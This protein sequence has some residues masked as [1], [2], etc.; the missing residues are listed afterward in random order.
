MKLSKFLPYIMSAVVPFVLFLINSFSTFI[1]FPF[2]VILYLQTFFGV[3]ALVN[4]ICLQKVETSFGHSLRLF[5]AVVDSW[6]S[7]REKIIELP[8]K[9][10]ITARDLVDTLVVPG[11][12]MN[13]ML[14]DTLFQVLGGSPPSHERI[15]ELLEKARQDRITQPEA[16]E[17]K[18]LLEEEK[19]EREAS[20]DI[21][22]SILLGLLIIF[23]L[24]VIASLFNGDG[25][26]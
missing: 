11:K 5:K 25:E 4:T 10:A 1:V 24:G 9:Q 6:K 16:E 21:I 15:K 8:R 3:I 19:A 22:G 12:E 18:K 17:L 2:D 13:G 23:I 20:G 14:T 26:D 7:M